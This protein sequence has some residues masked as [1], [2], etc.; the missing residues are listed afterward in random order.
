MACRS[1]FGPCS[2]SIFAFTGGG[3]G[4]A[5]RRRGDAPQ[6]FWPGIA[7]SLGVVGSTIALVAERARGTTHVM[8]SQGLPVSAYWAESFVLHA[9]QIIAVSTAIVLIALGGKQYYVTRASVRALLLAAAL[10][11]VSVLPLVYN[12]AFFFK[13]PEQA[14]KAFPTLLTLLLAIPAQVV[15]TLAVFDADIGFAAHALCSV[16]LPGYLFSSLAA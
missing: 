5:A 7:G 12:L 10:Q 4:N 16:L 2:T 3:R 14:T 9:V 13:T 15:A 1:E 11:P 8:L 6:A